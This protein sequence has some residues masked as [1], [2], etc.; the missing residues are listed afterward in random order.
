MNLPLSIPSPSVSYFQVGPLQIHFYALCILAGIIAAA[1]LTNHRL[2]KRGAERG[3]ILDMILWT[4]PF[5]IV[6]ARIFHVLTHP[7][8]YFFPG[9]ELWKVVAIWEGG[10]AIFGALIGGAIG[11][12][13]GCRVLGLRFW[14]FADALAPGLLLAQAFGRFGNYFNHELFGTPTN[15]WWGL[16]IE[17]S[18]PAYPIGLPDGT[19]FQPTFAYEVIWNL[20]G[21]AV[22]LLL[23]RKLGLQWGKVIAVYLIWYGLGRIVWESIRIDPS[24]IFF[25]L[26]VNVWAAI[27]AVVAGILIFVVQSRRHTGLEP[28]AYVPGREF[29]AT[30]AEV[31]SKNTD[32]GYVDLSEP[33]DTKPDSDAAVATSTTGSQK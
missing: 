24:E 5:G 4:V 31:D 20:L 25:G 29:N 1:L 15:G 7:N 16:E 10:I 19:L 22:I 13:I 11:A 18:N 21:V 27:F 12:Y 8:D 17:S 3:I 9:A 6:G 14:T 28:S 33:E 26:R 30:A 2:N 32:A 23:E